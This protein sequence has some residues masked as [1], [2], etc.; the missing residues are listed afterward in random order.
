MP[1]QAPNATYKIW[2]AGLFVATVFILLWGTAVLRL[3][4]HTN[5]EAFL[6]RNGALDSA[7]ALIA[8]PAVAARLWQMTTLL[9]KA[10]NA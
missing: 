5:G 3:M 8:P 4:Q 1:P 6:H 10:R 9:R 7:L 2:A